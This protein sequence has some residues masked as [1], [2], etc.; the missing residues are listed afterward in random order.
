MRY[1][2]LLT[3]NGQEMRAVDR[4]S[5][6]S[7]PVCRSV[8]HPRLVPATGP[9]VIYRKMIEEVWVWS[10]CCCVV[11]HC[12]EIEGVCEGK[13]EGQ[14][15]GMNSLPA[16]CRLP[17]AACHLTSAPSRRPCLFRTHTHPG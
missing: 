1:S 3:V 5:A 12:V 11:L 16:A 14:G 17:H 10:A 8:G 15:E 6:V 2:A 4:E 7:Q 9:I 13:G